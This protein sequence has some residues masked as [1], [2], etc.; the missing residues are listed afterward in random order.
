MYGSSESARSL[1]YLIQSQWDL[2]N[3]SMLIGSDNLDSTHFSI[4]A[5]FIQLSILLTLFLNLKQAQNLSSS[6]SSLTS[7]FKE[8]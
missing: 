4:K 1:D 5:N 6:G 8:R 2:S 3:F 7:N